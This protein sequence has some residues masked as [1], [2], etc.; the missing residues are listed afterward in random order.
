MR[1]LAALLLLPLVSCS[2]SVDPAVAKAE[3]EQLVKVYHEAYDQADFDAVLRMLDPEVALS[4]P[5]EGRFL[6]GR[7]ACGEQLKKDMQRLKD[8]GKVGKRKTFF[9]TIHVDVHGSLAIATYATLVKDE[10]T[11]STGLFTR[12]F[13]YDPASRRWLIYREHY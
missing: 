10:A 8:Q 9:E 13:R 7:D 11:P 1:I 5:S 12:I 4:R 3:V 6:H 2:G